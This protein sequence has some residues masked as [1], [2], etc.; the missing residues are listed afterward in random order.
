MHVC[1]PS[2]HPSIHP[3]YGLSLCFRAQKYTVKLFFGFLDIALSNAWIL[4]RSLHP[5]ETKFHRRWMTRLAE[6]LVNFNPLGEEVYEQPLDEV[7]LEERHL[8]VGLGL[9]KRGFKRRRQVVCRY[10]S[11]KKNRRRTSYG[12]QKCNVGLCKG[13][14]HRAWH[15]LPM[16]DRLKAMGVRK[17]MVFDDSDSGFSSDV[18]SNS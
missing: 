4:W 12:C 9:T 16:H 6:E 18:A 17:P 1:H 2:T 8:S 15:R 14:C 5:K 7:P 3:R 13:D 10:C 11:S